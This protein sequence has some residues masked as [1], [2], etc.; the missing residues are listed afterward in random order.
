MRRS[1]SWGRRARGDGRVRREVSTVQVRGRGRVRAGA[2]RWRAPRRCGSRRRGRCSLP[3]SRSES[4]R[5]RR[6]GTRRRRRP[7]SS[8]RELGRGVGERAGGAAVDR[9]LRGDRVEP[10]LDGPHRLGVAD[11]VEGAEPDCRRAFA[12]DLDRAQ[13]DG[14]GEDRRVGAVG[15]VADLV[16]AGAGV[17]RR[18]LDRDRSGGRPAGGAGRRVAGRARRGRR[19]SPR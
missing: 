16:D 14:A 18:Q 10:D 2:G 12:G 5:R 19:G 7:R 3:G 9:R 11:P 1:R 15:R 17:G 6:G 13:V 8:E 4:R